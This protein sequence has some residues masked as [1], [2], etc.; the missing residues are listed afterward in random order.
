MDPKKLAPATEKLVTAL[1]NFAFDL[2]ENYPRQSTLGLLKVL[3]IDNMNY[4]KGV[5]MQ[6]YALIKYDF[7]RGAFKNNNNIRD[8]KWRTNQPADWEIYI[9]D[10][11]EQAAGGRQKFVGL[12][13]P[14]NSIHAFFLFVI[15]K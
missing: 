1:Q 10:H 14:A 8:A 3:C 15:F 2:S 5:I 12:E 11:R 13:N 7:Q 6:F 9:E 4:A